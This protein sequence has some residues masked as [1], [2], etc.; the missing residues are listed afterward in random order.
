[1]LINWFKQWRKGHT[2]RMC[3]KRWRVAETN[4]NWQVMPRLRVGIGRPARK[5]LV[6]RHVL[7]RFSSEEKKVL[8]SVLVQSVDLLLSQLSLLDSQRKPPSS[9][10]GG[11]H[12]A[13][14]SREKDSSASPAADSAAAAAQSWR[15]SGWDAWE[16]TETRAFIYSIYSPLAYKVI[17]VKRLYWTGSQLNIRNVWV[18]T[19]GHAGC[20]DQCAK[21]RIQMIW[22][23]LLKLTINACRQRA[24][25]LTKA[26]IGLIFK[27]DL[28]SNNLR[29]SL[30]DNNLFQSLI[31]S[32]ETKQFCFL[33]PP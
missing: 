2:D 33:N 11:S 24:D 13:Q 18:H 16:D 20:A 5:T 32:L 25:N 8:D 9:P 10:A 17:K 4:L 3:F 27:A 29:L 6:E 7:G 15:F 23:F 30:F 31:C 19:C 26:S 22:P 1:M 21:F 14:C 12:A 28:A